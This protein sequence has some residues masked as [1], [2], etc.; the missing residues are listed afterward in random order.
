MSHKETRAQV[1]ALADLFLS[2]LPRGFA[3]VVIVGDEVEELVSVSH[4]TATRKDH[5]SLLTHALDCIA[6]TEND[7]LRAQKTD[8]SS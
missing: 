6:D 7:E 2:C 5:I 8:Q 4:K 1:L 3:A